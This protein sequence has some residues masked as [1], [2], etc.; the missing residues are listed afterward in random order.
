ML[1]KAVSMGVELES[2]WKIVVLLIKNEG[3]LFF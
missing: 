2:V 3:T 1:M